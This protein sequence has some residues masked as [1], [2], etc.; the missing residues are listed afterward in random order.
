MTALFSIVFSLPLPIQAPVLTLL[1]NDKILA[2]TKLKLFADDKANVAK[3]MTYVFDRVENIVGKGENAGY[4]H[5]L[6]SHNV[7][8]S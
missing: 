6:L 4:K 1:P 3:M 2:L 5:F 7:F 8:K